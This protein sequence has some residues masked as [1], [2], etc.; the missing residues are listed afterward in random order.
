[1]YS[2]GCTVPTCKVREACLVYSRNIRI[3]QHHW[4][5]GEAE[6]KKSRIKKV[7]IVLSYILVNTLLVLA[8]YRIVLTYRKSVGIVVICS[9]TLVFDDRKSSDM[10]N[11]CWMKN[12]GRRIAVRKRIVKEKDRFSSWKRR[13]IPSKTE[14][15]HDFPISLF[16]E[17]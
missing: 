3:V 9:W 15:N 1:M 14:K 4:Q 10:S 17:K 11:G 13:K 16:E 8:W 6:N 7:S 12:G 2:N 5:G